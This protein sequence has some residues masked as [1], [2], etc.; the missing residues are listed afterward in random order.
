[1][2]FPLQ[3]TISSVA[4]TQNHLDLFA[5]GNDGGIHSTWWDANV[6]NGA[7][8]HGWFRITDPH[9]GDGFTVNQR[10]K[11]AAVAR[12]SNHLDLFVVG[13][14][15]VVYSTWWDVHSG[16]AW[17]HGW[18][19][20]GDPN[21]G[22]GFTVNQTS[23]ISAVA[24]QPNHLDLF[25]VG[26][27]DAVYS[28]WWD[29]NASSGAWNHGWFRIGDAH[30]GDGFTV[31]QGTTIAAVARQ[32][33]HLDLFVI[34]KDGAI[35]STWWDAN[36]SGGAWKHGWFRIAD[37]HFGDGFT[38]N[39]TSTISAVA[40]TADHID[41]FV[42]GKDDAVY[43]T[44][45]D[46]NTGTAWNHGWFRIA[47]PHFGDNFTV[48]QGTFISSVART[49]DHLDLFVVGKDDAVYSTWWDANASGG[50][51]NHGWFRISD[52]HFGDGFTINQHS[53]ISAAAR[54]HDH[55]DLFVI[56]KDGNA[57]STW[58]DANASSG[59][60]NHGWFRI[61]ETAFTAPVPIDGGTALNPVDG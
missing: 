1:M 57:Y 60:W 21:F 19:R 49:T 7:W 61:Q 33:N 4:R 15:D 58:W 38:V 18:F 32:P 25:V 48:N 44:W 3:A 30:F 40:R 46:A 36:V 47:D 13:K 50:A 54:T 17:N 34:G 24:R 45:W 14:D 55:L 11:I 2:A 20:I 41:L 52:P 35:Y 9:F 51:W 37:P 56:G 53:V 23:T 22:D 29:A 43:S 26:K 31:N 16:P 39:Q 42:V 5:V 59:A 12:Q 6:S 28:T 27:D 10:T 8:N